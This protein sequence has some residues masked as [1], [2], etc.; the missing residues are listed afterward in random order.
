MERLSL[1]VHTV[2]VCSL[3]FLPFLMVLSEGFRHGTEA[4][5]YWAVPSQF[6]YSGFCGFH[7]RG[8]MIPWLSFFLSVLWFWGLVSEIAS[9]FL[10]QKFHDVQCIWVLCAIFVSHNLIE[11]I[12]LMGCF[13]FDGAFSFSLYVKSCHLWTGIISSSFFLDAL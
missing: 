3:T 9:W 2:Y 10:S 12:P 13:V 4:L 5:C 11:F 8:H 6:L 7:C 1:C